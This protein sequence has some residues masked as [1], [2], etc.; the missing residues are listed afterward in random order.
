MQN[1]VKKF[2]LIIE[3]VKEEDDEYIQ[4]FSKVPSKSDKL[5]HIEVERIKTARLTSAN[6]FAKRFK[7]EENED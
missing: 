4:T 1:E 7:I 2:N 5:E 6:P 3:G